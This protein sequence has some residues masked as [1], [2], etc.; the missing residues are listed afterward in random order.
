M[1]S[2]SHILGFDE[3]KKGLEKYREEKW[4]AKIELKSLPEREHLL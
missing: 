3:S 1:I 2:L 4:K